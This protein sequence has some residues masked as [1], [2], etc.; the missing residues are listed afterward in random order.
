MQ[1]QDLQLQ[2]IVPTFYRSMT[3]PPEVLP[4]EECQWCFDRF[5][6]FFVGRVRSVKQAVSEKVDSLVGGRKDPLYQ[7]HAHVGPNFAEL[8][9]PSIDDVKK[10]LG[11]I[12]G[13]SSNIDGI[14]TSLLKSCADIFV[15]LIARLAAL[16]FRDGKFPSRFEIASVTPLLKKPG[17]DSEVPGNYRPI[18]NLNNISKILER[19]FLRNII[20]TSAALRASTAASPPIVKTTPQRRPSFDSWMISTA[21]Q[22][23]NLEVY[24]SSLIYQRPSTHW[25]STHSFAVSSTHSV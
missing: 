22:T 18:S 15:P 2:E 16:S 12:P 17:L 1:E 10:I 25:T 5:I 9:P 7:D 4:P 19:L 3:S 21:P 20:V 14:P 13:K 8:D 24:W 23:R 6:E 11:S